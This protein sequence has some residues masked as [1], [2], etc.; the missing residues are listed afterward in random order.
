MPSHALLFFQIQNNRN[1]HPPYLHT[2]LVHQHAVLSIK[3]KKSRNLVYQE[4]SWSNDDVPEIHDG[5]QCEKWIW[6]WSKLN[7]IIELPI[8]NTI[9]LIYNT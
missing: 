5:V 8:K 1:I 2:V 9:N 4:G 6:S 7:I 3:A